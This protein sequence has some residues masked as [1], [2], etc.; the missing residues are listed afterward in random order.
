ML[1]SEL[2]VEI[3]K[4]KE[5]ASLTVKLAQCVQDRFAKNQDPLK[6]RQILHI[7]FEHL[8]TDRHMAAMYSVQ[9]VFNL[10]WIG[11]SDEQIL[12]FNAQFDD[13]TSGVGT[14]LDDNAI[15][16]VYVKCLKY[17]SRFRTLLEMYQVQNEVDRT[18]PWLRIRIQTDIDEKSRIKQ[19]AKALKEQSDFIRNAQTPKVDQKEKKEEKKDK[20]ERKKKDPRDTRSNTPWG[21]RKAGGKGKGKGKWRDKIPP[22]LPAH[23]DFRKMTPEEKRWNF[24]VCSFHNS[25]GCRNEA[26]DCK[27]A[28]VRPNKQEAAAAEAKRASSATP[29]KGKGKGKGK[30]KDKGKGKGKGKDKGKTRSNS[31]A[32]GGG[33]G[34]DRSLSRQQRTPA[35]EKE[36]AFCKE[37]GYC[38]T[39]YRTG[40]CPKAG[41]CRYEHVANPDAKPNGKPKSAA[42]KKKAKKAAAAKN[43]NGK[44]VDLKERE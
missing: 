22:A 36:F 19:R 18:L 17:S 10:K 43:V 14:L 26:K 7:L 23:E 29:A 27:Y 35:E 20:K 38:S 4:N 25:T 24:G 33:K 11:D 13:T 1:A 6:G 2:T 34:G 30:G 39:F 3:C 40:A 41:D 44:E 31:W 15:R 16:D 8:K 21:N 9:D 37:K 12:T 28:H 42:A 32:P 5:N